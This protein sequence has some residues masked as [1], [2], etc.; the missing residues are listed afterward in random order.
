MTIRMIVCYSWK[1]P[2]KSFS[3]AREKLEF[4]E[5]TELVSQREGL[6]HDLQILGLTRTSIH[7][8]FT[9]EYRLVMA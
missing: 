1:T 4:S 9:R 3:L 8:T 6:E 2:W 5:V 7:L